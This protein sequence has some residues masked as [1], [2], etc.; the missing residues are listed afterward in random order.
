[1]AYFDIIIVLAVVLFLIISLYADLFKP[2]T[3]F[4]IA[5]V[6]LSTFKI[7]SAQEVL[8]GFANEQ[9]AVIIL[10]L[11][12][13]NIVQKTTLVDLIFGYF[14]NKAKTYRGFLYRMILYVSSSSAFFNNTPLVAMMM[15]YVS[16][17]S[18]RNK[19]SPSKLLIPL[20]YAA[21]LGGCATLI[22]TSTNLLVNGMAVANGIHN[23]H[24]FDFAYVG[25]PMV[26]IGG[27]YM[28]LFAKRLLP[29]RKAIIGDYTD[30]P[31]QYTVEA[32]VHRRS[33]LIGKTL[34]EAKLKNIKGLMLI[35]VIRGQQSVS[36]VVPNFVL[37]SRD[38]LI[39]AGETEHIIEFLK[40]HKDLS[41]P[42][43]DRITIKSKTNVV[44]V[45]VSQNSTL[46]NNRIRKG[47]FR[48]RYDAAIVAIHRNG[49]RLTGRISNINLK[50]GDVLLLAAGKGFFFRSK[51]TND[52][53]FISKVHEIHKLSRNHRL[54]LM[55]GLILA[56]FLSALKIITLF[57]ALI[58]LLALVVLLKIANIQDIKDS[59]EFKIIAIDGMA[60]G[61]GKAMINSGTAEWISE[62]ILKGLE[63]LGAVGLL[64][65]VF[66]VTSLLA[67]YMTNVAAIS[68]IFP[69]SLSMAQNMLANGSITSITPFILIVAYGGAANFLSPIGYQTNLMVYGAGG[70]SFKD[71][72][73]IGFPLSILY[74]TVAVIVLA[75]VYNLW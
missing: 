61:L 58:I 7:L 69:I 32:I 4:L 72:L 59:I 2:I 27:V 50:A 21:I 67:S 48:S 46:I 22:G 29:N 53:Y 8:A 3:A 5:I 13:S 44:E 1:M 18:R 73:K 37:K 47:D 62:Y 20:S 31:R 70:Y 19:I 15:P 16:N 36:P 9:I 25:L 17:W 43:A 28:L 74:A 41:V 24:I 10:L 26:L 55:G 14:F 38:R 40:M 51:N 45:V 60:L 75:F 6:T 39:F 54:V 68:I 65:G 66:V 33:R 56:I 11:I 35:E 52:F 34:E 49:E 64:A 57:K 42:Q 23:I 63:P 71:F 30:T 12:F